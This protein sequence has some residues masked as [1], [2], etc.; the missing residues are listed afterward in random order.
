MVEQSS[1]SATGHCAFVA[2]KLSREEWVAKYGNHDRF[3]EYD[4]NGDGVVD[5]DEFLAG[6]A[7][8]PLGAH[9]LLMRGVL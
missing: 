2:A 9:C 3:D 6:Q 8:A 4:A 5:A 7:P 1:T